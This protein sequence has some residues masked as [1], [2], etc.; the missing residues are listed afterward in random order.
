MK[1]GA[2]QMRAAVKRLLIA[3]ARPEVEVTVQ[4]RDLELLMLARV[5]AVQ[6]AMP[7]LHPEQR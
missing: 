6:A 5:D 4:R 1:V 3:L 7:N 2:E